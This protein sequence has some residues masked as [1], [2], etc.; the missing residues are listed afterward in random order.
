M[1]RDQMQEG[2]ELLITNEILLEKSENGE[3]LSVLT[4][5][6][7]RLDD[8]QTLINRDITEAWASIIQ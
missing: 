8:V 5:N 3:E 6:P 7:E 2:L 1:H 4:I